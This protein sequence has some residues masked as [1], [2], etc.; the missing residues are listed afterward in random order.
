MYYSASTRSIT[1]GM[2]F[3]SV[4]IG[5]LWDVGCGRVLVVCQYVG[6]CEEERECVWEREIREKGNQA[7]WKDGR[8]NDGWID[9]W[10]DEL[11]GYS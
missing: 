6:V 3:L 2:C 8:M 1:C 11:M 9:G 5:L 10:I 4:W 7:V